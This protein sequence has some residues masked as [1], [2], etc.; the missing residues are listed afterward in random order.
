MAHALSPIWSSR[1]ALLVGAA[2]AVA[3]VWLLVSMVWLAVDGPQVEPAA[4]PPVPSPAPES[5]ANG[6]FDWALFGEARRQQPVRVESAPASRSSL[7]LKGVVAAGEHGYAIIADS[8]GGDEVF[9]VG[10][11]LP[12]GAHIEAI[13]P[14]RVLISR[15]GRTEALEID[16]ERR[17]PDA[18]RSGPRRSAATPAQ[19]PGIRGLESPDGGSVSSM[20]SVASV[21]DAAA[22]GGI[23]VEEL[24]GAISVMPVA[25]GGYRVRPGRDA[26][27]FSKLG[28]QVNDVVMAVNGQPLES[29]Q[30]VRGL[31]ADVMTSGQVAIT[32]VRD[33]REMTLRPDLDEILESLE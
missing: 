10:D 31:F 22:S 24:A 30:A 33:G 29:E 5:R 16:P 3:I 23:N 8:Q 19:L 13:E 32:V 6:D 21:A 20:A 1:L 17:R 28:L 14:R 12:D 25:D 7:R 4:M 2:A 27:L 11:E 15:S 9:R 26:E 18:G